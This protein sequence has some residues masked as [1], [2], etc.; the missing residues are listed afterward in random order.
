MKL[1]I[2]KIC[3]LYAALSALDGVEEVHEIN[4]KKTIVKKPYNFTGKVRWNLAKNMRILKPH[5]DDVN[6]IRDTLIKEVSGGEDQIG[7]GDKEKIK[8]FTTKYTEVNSQEEDVEGL[9][10]LSPKDLGLE[11]EDAEKANKIPLFVLDA[12]DVLVKD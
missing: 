7:E 5:V 10:V 9:L 12:L 2:S 1:K 6:K 8:E 11:E 4:D 3:Q